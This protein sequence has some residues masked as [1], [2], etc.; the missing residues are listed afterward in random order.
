MKVLV[1]PNKLYTNSN[2]SIKLQLPSYSV[3]EGEGTN[4]T[5]NG[6]SENRM[7]ADL[8]GNTSQNG[9]PTPSTPIDV[10]VVSGFNEVVV[11]N[12]NL[13]NFNKLAYTTSSTTIT[14]VDDDTFT[15]Y[16]TATNR[17]GVWIIGK[18]T[19]F[20]GKSLTAKMNY[21]YSDYTTQYS[22]NSFITCDET[23][24]N[25]VQIGAI[26]SYS[27]GVLS[28]TRAID[29]TLDTTKYIGIRLYATSGS[30]TN[31]NTY[32]N[33]Q[34][35]IGDTSTDYIQHQEQEYELNLGKNK[36]PNVLSVDG[37]QILQT[38]CTMTLDG[39]TYNFMASGADAYWGNTVASGSAYNKNRGALVEIPSNA[40]NVYLKLTN[41]NL[42]K[43]FVTW[44]DSSKTSLGYQQI[45]G[46]LAIRSGAKYLSVRIGI[47]SPT[48]GETYTT[49]IMVAFEDTDYAPY[50]EPIE[51][52]KIGNYQDKIYRNNGKWWLHK[53]IYK[54]KI[55]ESNVLQAY[56]NGLVGI[57]NLDVYSNIQ[58]SYLSNMFS[59]GGGAVNS[60][61]A[62]SYGNNTF[63]VNNDTGG[64][65]VGRL[66]YFR[67]D[68]INTLA[69]WKTFFNNNDV[70][71]YGVLA[72][73]TDTEITTA[74]LV[75][76]LD[77]MRENMTTYTGQTNINQINSDLP[78]YLKIKAKV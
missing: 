76:E 63:A 60:S 46:S 73:P 57:R 10:E 36:L 70:Y 34:V 41:S 59:Y 35:E 4:V 77:N 24:N 71:I 1:E 26:F 74:S 78:F 43:N 55:T 58:A 51:L 50:F 33:V 12:K 64:V 44:Y 15:L 68:N 5:L 18:V 29:N 40:T 11:S 53:E 32:S 8:Y 6:T 27:N 54:F 13:F 2:M 9:T 39:D 19:D 30:G 28:G 7:I 61:G 69:D 23:G 48:I 65:N 37:T 67:N 52:C 22:N 49:G 16:S 62:Y 66:Y 3:I 42:A 20:I 72:T 14:K 47:N 17:F 38:R 75:E 21:S 45:S 25:R 56:S 31:T